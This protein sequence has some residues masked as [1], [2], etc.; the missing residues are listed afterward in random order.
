M[1]TKVS[2]EPKVRLTPEEYL[3]LERK[4]E[5][6]SEYLDGEMFAMPG[7]T[8]QHSQIVV[9]LAIDL[10]TQLW[11]RPFEVHGPELRVKVAATGLYTYPDVFIA[12][13]EP[14]IEGDYDDTVLDPLVI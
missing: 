5:T 7:V 10:G 14:H 2:T 8:R 4:A 1:E 3:E 11:D 9:N 6:K 13:H 12:G